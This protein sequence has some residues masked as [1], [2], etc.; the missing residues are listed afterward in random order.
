MTI[1]HIYMAGTLAAVA[2]A[3]GCSK[4]PTVSFSSDVLPVLERHCQECH[5]A[6][7]A[8]T[9]RSGFTVDTYDSVMAG[10]KLGPMVVPGDPLS[11]NLYR[12]VAGEVDESIRMPHQQ[13]AMAAE[14]I[15]V[16]RTWIAEG[17]LDN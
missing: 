12:L 17:A 16:I 13:N 6:G 4:A 5:Q 1:K 8:G 14:E 10:T 15:D 2:L 3:A 7:G 11:S 9:E